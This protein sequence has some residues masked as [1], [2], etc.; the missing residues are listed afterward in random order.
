VREACVLPVSLCAVLGASSY[1][2]AEANWT[3]NLWD[4]LGSHVR[5]F[6]YFL[7]LCCKSDAAICYGDSVSQKTAGT[8]FRGRHFRDV[9]ILL[10][11]RW[12]LRY[13]LSYRDLER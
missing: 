5:A 2:Y 4:W 7:W 9:V 6:E 13:S 12:Y 8:V 10:C 3:R 1:T 11:V